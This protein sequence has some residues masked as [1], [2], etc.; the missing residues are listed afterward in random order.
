[1]VSLT[2]SRNKHRT[3]H[4]RVLLAGRKI[5]GE[6]LTPIPEDHSCRE[7]DNSIR[8]GSSNGRPSDQVTTES[9]YHLIDRTR[10]KHRL[11]ALQRSDQ[12][13]ELARHH[14]ERMAKDQAVCHSVSN[15][16]ELQ[17]LLDSAMVGE[18]IQRGKSATELHQTAM[19]TLQVNRQNVLGMD[20]CEYGV[21][22]VRGRDDGMIYMCQYFR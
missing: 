12:L 7:W 20:F 2:A 10:R 13:H 14:A 8:L 4:R 5:A 22:A 18:N 19:A 17:T 21:A 11:H 15:I 3:G 6:L 1:M 16:Q 9:A